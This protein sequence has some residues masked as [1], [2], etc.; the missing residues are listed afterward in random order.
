MTSR[1]KTSLILVI[2]F[3]VLSVL[4]LTTAASL[5]QWLF[6]TKEAVTSTNG[7]TNF[8]LLGIPG[9]AHAGQDLTDTL[10][11]FSL[12]H[13]SGEAVLIS[14]PRDIW[15]TPLRAKLNTVY[16]YKG[17]S[18]TKAAVAEILGQ[19]IHYAILL[20]FSG[21][22]KAIDALGGVEVDVQKAFD[23]YHYPIPGKE[24]DRCNGDP[25]YRCRYEHLHFEAGLQWL[26]GER[27]LKFVRSRFASGDEGTD[28]ARSRRQ[29]QIIAAVKKKIFSWE[30]LT[31]FKR[32]PTLY[33]IFNQN[34]K[35][36]IPP[37]AYFGLAQLALR[38]KASTI[39][40]ADIE[41][42]LVNPPTSAQ[43]DFHWVLIPR[44]G[45][46][47]IHQAIAKILVSPEVKTASPN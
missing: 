18:Q 3:G 28:F 8:L 12:D 47:E 44:N 35:T 22:S 2:L 19:P 9:E 41:E 40:T 21:F 43:Y 10:I 46:T 32:L 7:R 36:D 26:D 25:Q 33:E 15:I 11:F 20:D 16:H 39:T 27:A 45:W 31:D 6:L 1:L 37:S 13:Q 5:H 23:D 14:L 30:T 42:F 29:E 4:F 24:N 38:F 34:I 17:L